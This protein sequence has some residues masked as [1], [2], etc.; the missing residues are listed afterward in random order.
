MRTRA[1]NFFGLPGATIG[2]GAVVLLDAV[3]LFVPA[4]FFMALI[5][6][7]GSLASGAEAVERRK[8]LA[9]LAE[10]GRR[11]GRAVLTFFECDR[12][13]QALSIVQAF[14]DDVGDA[15]LVEVDHQRAAAAD[16]VHLALM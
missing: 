5:V 6:F 11:E 14:P 8:G 16:G 12:S 1:R 2:S 13:R 4:F 7:V 3:F 9:A 10:I 15:C